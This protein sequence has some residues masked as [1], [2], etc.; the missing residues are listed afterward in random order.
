MNRLIAILSKKFDQK[1]LENK[2]K[3]ING[4]IEAA[5][6]NAET[7]LLDIEDKMANTLAK[8][9]DDVEAK[10]IINELKD[11]IDHESEVKSGIEALKRIK[12]YINEPVEVDE[13]PKKK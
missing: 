13:T 7:D 10:V 4:A 8:L 1:R 3:R 9:E 5:L 11:I 12:D 6:T 2:V